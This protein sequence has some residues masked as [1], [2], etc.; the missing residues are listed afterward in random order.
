MG[1]FLPHDFPTL[2][3]ALKCC[4]NNNYSCCL[5]RKT[6]KKHASVNTDGCRGIH[7]HLNPCFDFTPAS[8]ASLQPKAWPCPG[9][10]GQSLTPD[11]PEE[12]RCGTSLIGNANHADK[13][14]TVQSPPGYPS[15]PPAFHPA[16]A[17]SRGSPVLGRCG[18]SAACAPLTPLPHSRRYVA[19][20]QK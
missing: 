7:S 1:E 18:D 6:E 17:Q 15:C 5:Q 9:S 10:R 4:V 8:I 16:V 14:K 19:T 12:R 3:P 13:D 20:A 11:C 2:L